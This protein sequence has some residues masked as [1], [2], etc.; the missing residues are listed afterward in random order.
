[1]VACRDFEAHSLW[2]SAFS[3][4]SNRM[5]YGTADGGLNDAT[6]YD[7]RTGEVIASLS[8]VAF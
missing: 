2:Q 3:N 1:M 4:Y 6:I 8:A 7:A 5:I